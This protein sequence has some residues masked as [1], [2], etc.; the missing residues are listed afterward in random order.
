[1]RKFYFLFIITVLT[2]TGCS[3]DSDILAEKGN[4]LVFG[5]F[6]GMCGSD[7]GCVRM[8]KLTDTGLY[9]DTGADYSLTHFNFSPLSQEKFQLVQD[10]PEILPAELL[11]EEDDVLG[12]PDC[13]DQ[14]GIFIIR[15]QDGTIKSWRIDQQKENVPEYLHNFIDMVNTKIALLN[16]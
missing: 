8:Y 3:K 1:M 9:S 12:C 10:L 16:N 4:Y 14:G 15:V 11:L 5:D 13:A 2:L 6:Y 7:S